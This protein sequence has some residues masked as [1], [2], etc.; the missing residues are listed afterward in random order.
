[1]VAVGVRPKKV[2]GFVFIV[3][4]NEKGEEDWT[5]PRCGSRLRSCCGNSHI[6]CYNC[7]FELWSYQPM[8]PEVLLENI[9]QV[10]PSTTTAVA[11]FMLKCRRCG[12]VFE[13]MMAVTPRCPKCGGYDLEVIDPDLSG[14]KMIRVDEK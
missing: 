4:V 11:L 2:G 8:I 14:T 5:C 12:H 13:S 7:G 10:K 9:L 1:M 3:P 6:W